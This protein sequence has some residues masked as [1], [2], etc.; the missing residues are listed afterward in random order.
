MNISDCHLL[1]LGQQRVAVVEVDVLVVGHKSD[2]K[3]DFIHL[4][5]LFYFLFLFYPNIFLVPVKRIRI[6]NSSVYNCTIKNEEPMYKLTQKN[7]IYL[8]FL[9]IESGSDLF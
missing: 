5:L 9:Y 3:Q 2:L 6:H 4:F 7:Y 1:G 8:L